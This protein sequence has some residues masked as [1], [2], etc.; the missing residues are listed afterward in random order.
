[1]NIIRIIL[2][3][4]VV[5]SCSETQVWQEIETG[6]TVKVF[7]GGFSVNNTN[8]IYKWSKPIGPENSES[9]YS[10]EHDKLLFTPLSPG[11]YHI[12][13]EIENM[14]ETKVYEETFYF[15]VIQ[16]SHSNTLTA[17]NSSTKN[18]KKTPSPKDN[19]KDRVVIN[20]R[21]TI[22]VA[23][24]TSLE[25]A[26]TDMRELIAL[27]FDTYI[28]EYF[29]AN[30]NIQRWRVRIGS[31]KSKELAQNVKNKLSKFRGE[32]PWIAYIK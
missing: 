27:G 16:G 22:Q 17:N 8:Y 32:D 21:Y 11:Q 5:I 18:D 30:N 14:M 29:D 25:K 1:M 2:C 12:S 13:L 15:N 4:F 7:S 24:W 3:T 23:S 28:E 20:N 9:N 10:I 6:K 31:F 26:K 19:N